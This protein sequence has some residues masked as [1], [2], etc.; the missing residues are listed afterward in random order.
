MNL[1][2]LQ[3]LALE[4]GFTA[5]EELDADTIELR[6]EVRKMC[7]DNKCRMY[8]KNWR[9]P[10]GCG[11]LEECEKKV[12][13]YKKGILV[14][15]MGELEDEMDVETM[16]ELEASHKEHFE[17]M[18]ECLA[19]EY[20]TMLSLGSGTCTKCKVCTYP[21]AP[22]RFPNHTFASMEAYG[23]L[24]MDVCKANG[25]K[26]YYGPCTIAYTSCFLLEEKVK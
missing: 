21:D 9:C 20:P 14:Q 5:A 2:K 7:E 11:T 12:R 8:G 15:T 10:P 16:M 4:C 6:P 18:R 3:K 23:M 26:Y 19:E 17:K 24:V 25:L 13:S 22:C 1:E